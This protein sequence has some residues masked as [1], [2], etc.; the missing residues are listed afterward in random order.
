M[1]CSEGLTEGHRPKKQFEQLFILYKFRHFI[2][3]YQLSYKLITLLYWL[4][5]RPKYA[6][7]TSS[8]SRKLKTELRELEQL[9]AITGESILL[10]Y[11]TSKSLNLT[12][13]LLCGKQTYWGRPPKLLNLLSIFILLFFFKVPGFIWTP[14]TDSFCLERKIINFDVSLFFT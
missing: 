11:W 5:C 13:F 2:M 10:G 4:V 12:Q 1:N 14:Q 6:H 9:R 7:S 8:L 3:K